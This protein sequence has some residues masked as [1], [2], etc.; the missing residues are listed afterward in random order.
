VREIK[1][2]GALYVPGC[3]TKLLSPQHLAQVTDMPETPIHRKTR[4][5][6]YGDCIV[7][8]WSKDGYTK[9]LQLDSSNLGTMYTVPGYSKFASYYN[10]VN[11]NNISKNE[12]THECFTAMPLNVGKPNKDEVELTGSSQ[13]SIKEDAQWSASDLKKSTDTLRKEGFIAE[14]S[15]NMFKDTNHQQNSLSET[16]TFDK[17]DEELMMII[18]QQFSHIPFKRIAR[19]AANGLLPKRL[20]TCP[21]PVGQACIYGKLTR[22]LWRA[23]GT[24]GKK[25]LKAATVAGEVVSVDQLESPVEGF[26]AQLKGSLFQTKRYTCA[27]IFVDH[28]SDL[29]YVHPQLSTSAEE[30]IQAKKASYARSIGVNVKQYH[31]DYG[32]FAEK[33]WRED[34]L[35]QGQ[36]LSFSGVGAHH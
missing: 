24:L 6:A 19:M 21:I 13:K 33:L 16:S 17:R 18:H 29:S 12:I 35:L 34:V 14:F 7:L 36:L 23:K 26:V 4:A 20:A 3:S 22:K 10:N 1:L 15:D 25:E 30:T 31:A 8:Q 32:R 11:L 28:Y 9:T 27:T 2:P 5:I